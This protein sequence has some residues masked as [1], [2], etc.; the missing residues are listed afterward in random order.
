V[1]PD[2]WTWLRMCGLSS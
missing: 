2:G 1:P